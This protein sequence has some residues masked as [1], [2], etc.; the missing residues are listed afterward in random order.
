LPEPDRSAGTE[1]EY[2]A[3]RNYVEQRIISILEDV[4]G[5]ERMSI[6]C[7]FFDK[8]GN[9]LKAMQAVHS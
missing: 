8:G 5:T 4:L 1:A 7:H 3:P 2:E 9:S 6:S